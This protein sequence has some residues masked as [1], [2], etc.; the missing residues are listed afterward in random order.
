MAASVFPL[1][2]HNKQ[3][4]RVHRLGVVV[5]LEEFLVQSLF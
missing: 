4:L 2:A 1:A 3:L 5:V